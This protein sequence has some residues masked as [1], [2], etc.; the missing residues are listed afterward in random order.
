MLCPVI[1]SDVQFN[2]MQCVYF[3]CFFTWC[4]RKE[5]TWGLSRDASSISKPNLGVLHH[6]ALYVSSV[7][8]SKTQIGLFLECKRGCS[9]GY[10][11]SKNICLFF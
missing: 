8:L 4:K 5:K 1:F 3:L 6:I 11:K 10:A 2:R 9:T 7:Y